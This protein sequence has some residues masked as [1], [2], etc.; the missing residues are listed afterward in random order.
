MIT[1]GIVSFILLAAA[2]VATAPVAVQ[3]SV[4]TWNLF[5]TAGLVP[6]CVMLLYGAI[7][8]QLKARDTRDAQ[9]AKLQ[10]EA[11]AAK[12]LMLKEKYESFSAALCY[13]KGIVE[14]ISKEQQERV[15]WKHCDDV[16]RELR[17][18]IR[19]INER[20]IGK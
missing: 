5:L 6:F 18:E 11:E 12:M 13:V 19:N 3:E 15:T 16:H 4:L 2:S 9:I 14:T 8:R 17:Q 20:D 10:A 1:L 7:T